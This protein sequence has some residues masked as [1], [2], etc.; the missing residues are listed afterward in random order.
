MPSRK[1]E[2][3]SRPAHKPAGKNVRKPNEKPLRGRNAEPDED[4]V[5]TRNADER[6]T[7]TSRQ[8]KKPQPPV[9]EKAAKRVEPEDSRA[10]EADDSV[11]LEGAVKDA[12]LATKGVI[13]EKI[14]GLIRLAKEQGF[15][16][17]KDINKALPGDV[18]STEE[19]ENVITILENLEI[20]IIESDD[21]EGYKQ[22]QE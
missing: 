12:D 9:K 1:E 19:I 15:L 18:E 20:D 5:A 11:D 3:S 6:Q 10:D 13:N 14:G 17:Y 21:V 7:P 2:A 16:T 4:D 22:R 8:A